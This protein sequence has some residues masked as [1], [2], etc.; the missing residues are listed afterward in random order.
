MDSITDFQQKLYNLY[1][2]ALAE[3]QGRG[4]RNRYRWDNLDTAALVTL[5]KLEQF[6]KS[7]ENINPSDFFKA[8]FELSPENWLPIEHFKTRKAIAQYTK[9]MRGRA[10]AD[11]DTADS[12]TSYVEGIKFILNFVKENQLN[13]NQYKEAKN[14]VG[15]PYYM[16]HLHD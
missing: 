16:I 10:V 13:L 12:L 6:F 5:I 9:Y 14:G 15:V 7:N 3:K 11:P 4:F 2:S 8:G 1:L